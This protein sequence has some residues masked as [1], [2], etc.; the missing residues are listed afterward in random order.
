MWAQGSIL[1]T[2]VATPPRRQRLKKGSIRNS[3]SVMSSGIPKG[4]STEKNRRR[5]SADDL[6]ILVIGSPQSRGDRVAGE[7]A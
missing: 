6:K 4:V 1:P 3:R 5:R 7:S 2:G